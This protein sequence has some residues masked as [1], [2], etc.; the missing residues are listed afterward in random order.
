M[1]NRRILLLAFVLILTIGNYIRLTGNEKI[2]LIQFLSISLIGASTALLIK[3]LITQ[4][5][6]NN[7]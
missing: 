5:K 7:K 1:K 4:L 6:Q 3:E 2:R